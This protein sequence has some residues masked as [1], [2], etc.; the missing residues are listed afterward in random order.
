MPTSRRLSPNKVIVDIL[1]FDVSKDEVAY[2][3]ITNEVRDLILAKALLPGT[4][5]PT[6]TELATLWGTNYFTVQRALTPLVNE[7]LLVRKQ[8]RGTFVAD[9]KRQIRSVGIYLGG[10]FWRVKHAA[11]Y[12]ALYAA[13]CDHFERLGITTHL[14]MDSRPRP[15]QG[16]PWKPLVEAIGRSEVGGVIGAMLTQD[17]ADWLEQLPVPV[18]LFGTPASKKSAVDGI[19]AD[20]LRNGMRRLKA[21]GCRSVAGISGAGLTAFE[22][23][24]KYAAEAGLKTRKSWVLQRDAW[25][26]DFEEFGFE[27]IRKIWA[28]EAKPDGLIVYPDSIAVGVIMGILQQGIRVPEDLKLVM[29]CNEEVYFHCPMPADWQVVSIVRIV[30]ALWRHLKAQSDGAAPRRVPVEVVMH[31]ASAAE[32][33][34]RRKFDARV[35]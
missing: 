16:T 28:G 27:S 20:F 30:E 8:R 12:Q 21:R 35:S 7:G 17:E 10:S 33:P 13:L 5:L 32:P 2:K 11:F 22:E 26:E 24:E 34:Q 9:N 4:R 14:F 19:S 15:Q 23:F 1:N 29:H 6:L 25:P 18:S 31:P 3:R